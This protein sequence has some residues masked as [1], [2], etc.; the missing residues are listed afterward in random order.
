M[1]CGF[2]SVQYFARLCCCPWKLRV[3]FGLAEGSQRC[4]F[5][6]SATHLKLLD[7]GAEL[8]YLNLRLNKST[9]RSD[10][11]QVGNERYRGLRFLPMMPGDLFE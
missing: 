2:V 1:R 10:P 8:H 11:L 3:T 7:M 4:D 5:A 9:N 6:V